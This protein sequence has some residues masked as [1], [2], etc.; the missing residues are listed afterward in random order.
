LA[1]PLAK[2]WQLLP[3]DRFAVERLADALRC[4]FIVAQL[5][6]NRGL[7]T[8]DQARRFLDAP[9]NG[10]HQPD[11]LPGVTQAVECITAAIQAGKK[12]CVYGDYDVDGVS[13]SAILLQV[14]KLL[15]AQVD[16][17]LPLRLTEGY[18]LN[19][20]ALREIARN[21]A[22]MVITVDCGIASIDE[23]EEARKLGLE[24]IVTDHH[25][26]KDTLPNAA[27]LVHP[28]LPGTS[29]PFGKL[30]G[31]AVAFK[32]AWA[33]A[34][35]DS[36]GPKVTQRFRDFLLDSVALASL[37]IVADVVPLHDENRI[38]VRHGLA[39]MMKSPLP[40]L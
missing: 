15:R 12:I 4:S 11:L 14:L 13:G 31:S 2:S 22:A 30:S 9:L 3:H 28:R 27:V 6:L 21:G 17:Y 33:L 8:P 5:L 38:L 39:R 40:G 32:L 37:G 29:Y 34:Q 16:L 7:S 26:F 20:E 36:G 19:C 25:E 35:R 23:A 24:L 10:L 1:A 18:G